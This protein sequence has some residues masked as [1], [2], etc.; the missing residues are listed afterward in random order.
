MTEVEKRALELLEAEEKAASD[1]ALTAEARELL[2]DP[3]FLGSYEAYKDSAAERE[4][5]ESNARFQTELMHFAR[6][7]RLIK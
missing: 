7:N 5:K 2:K 4:A 1:A 6:K 3:D